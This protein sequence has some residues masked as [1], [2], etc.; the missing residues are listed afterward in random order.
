MLKLFKIVVT[1]LQG[2]AMNFCYLLLL[3]LSSCSVF[4]VETPSLEL[5]RTDDVYIHGTQFLSNDGN[6]LIQ[7]SGNT[8]LNI[9]NTTISVKSG[10]AVINNIIDHC[11]NLQLEPGD[12]CNIRFAFSDNKTEYH[13]KFEV[14]FF[15]NYIKSNGKVGRY[16]KV[17]NIPYYVDTKDVKEYSL[18]IETDSTTS[19]LQLFTG[20][21]TLIHIIIT[22]LNKN[23]VNSI[24]TTLDSNDDTK[25]AY[26]R[27]LDQENSCTNR[28]L[29]YHDKCK[30]TIE[31]LPI[32]EVSNVTLG[33]HVVAF[34]QVNDIKLPTSDISIPIWY[35]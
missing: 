16:L 35:F 19:S 27:I 14:S 32:N 33:V 18:M 26:F 25:S 15:N 3:L 21:K 4:S 1:L 22:N 17:V 30:Y 9:I 28:T 2:C 5:Q 12:Y 7:N 24:K 13:K 20:Q 10:S 23:P 29:L 8:V 11:T 31:V 6:V 34:D